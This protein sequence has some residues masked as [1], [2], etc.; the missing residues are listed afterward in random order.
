[1]RNTEVLHQVGTK[2]EIMKIISLRELRFL[3]HV[4]RL[5]QLKNVCVTGKVEG[6]RGKERPRVICIIELN[7]IHMNSEPK[8]DA[9]FL[10]AKATLKKK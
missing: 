7:D 1:M 8:Q 10:C 2:R 5:Q 6:R 4:M 9:S 3:G